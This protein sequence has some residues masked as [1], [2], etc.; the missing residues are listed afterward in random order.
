M[1]RQHGLNNQQQSLF[2]GHQNMNGEPSPV[3]TWNRILKSFKKQW[4]KTVSN[5]ISILYMEIKKVIVLVIAVLLPFSCDF[6]ECKRI[7]DTNFY[8]LPD[9]QGRGSYLY[10][11]DDERG[12]FF[13]ITHEGIV[14]D[15]Y[16]N[17]RFVIIKC[18]QS[19]DHNIKYW[20]IIK[21][22]KKYS[23]KR[24]EIKQFKNVGEYEIALDT[25]GVSEKLMN[26]TDGTIP[27]RIS[28]TKP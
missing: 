28:F 14:R 5:N 25:I 11:D 26:H 24:F 23:W 1:E 10:H 22:I 4:C 15:V 3:H 12:G 18:S 7:G 6:T 27:W 8:L 21:N 17:Q 9:W 2:R 20:Y 19:D 13:P 16:W